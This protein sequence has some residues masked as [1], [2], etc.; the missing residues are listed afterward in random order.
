MSLDNI[1]V[2]ILVVIAVSA[3]IGIRMHAR[4]KE[5]KENSISSAGEK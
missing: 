4:M 3:V 2:I 5:R 1:I